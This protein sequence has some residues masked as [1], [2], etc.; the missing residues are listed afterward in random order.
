MALPTKLVRIRSAQGASGAINQIDIPV[1]ASQTIKTGDF[2]KLA[3]NKATQALA[4]P[5]SNNSVT[6][7]TG[8]IGTIGIA[9][10]DITSDSNGIEAISGRTTIPV[11][12][13]DGNLE[14][15][16][17]IVNDSSGTLASTTTTQ[18]DVNFGTKYNF[19]RVRGG[20]A[21]TWFYALTAA[22]PTNGELLKVENSPET[23]STENYGLV[24][25]RTVN[26]DTVRQL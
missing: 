15:T 6:N 14:A 4:L 12:I 11:A 24:T 21:S 3:S 9:M 19:A 5:G 25:V 10:A 2:V 26:T 8:N 23:T 20:D 18:G 16:L 22:S 17:R 13:W 1:A 7:S